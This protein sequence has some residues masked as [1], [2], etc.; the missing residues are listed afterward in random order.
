MAFCILPF[1]HSYVHT[2]GEIFPCCHSWMYPQ[3]KMGDTS[4]DLEDVFN[5]EKYRK[6]RLDLL[7]DIQRPEICSKCYQKEQRGLDSFRHQHNQCFEHRK[8]YAIDNTDTTGYIDPKFFYFD[9]RF[10]NLCNMKCRTCTSQCSSLWAAENGQKITVINSIPE[11]KNVFEKHYQHIERIY[12][13][14]GEPLIMKEHFHIIKDLVDRGY[15]K[16]IDLE[17]NTNLSKLD[18]GKYDFVELWK[19]FKSLKVMASIDH[20]FEKAEYIRHGTV[21]SKIESNLDKLKSAGTTIHINCTVSVFNILD[22]TEIAKYLKEKGYIEN[23]KQFQ[24]DVLT[25]PNYYSIYN[26]PKTLKNEAKDRILFWVENF[27][28]LLEQK[29]KWVSLAKS[30]ENSQEDQQR[31]VYFQIET[32]IIDSKRSENFGSL[33]PEIYKYFH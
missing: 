16:N 25:N 29:Q 5:N 3:A 4:Q 17:Y 9:V 18:Y 20:I 13:A 12:F 19:N 28:G 6:F 23:Y 30:L 27:E 26:L 24:F 14:G 33:F 15:S 32:Q 8:Q 7:N 21:W 1:L 11:N 10:S 2:T 22:I 31:F